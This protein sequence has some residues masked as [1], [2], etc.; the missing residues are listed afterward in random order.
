MSDSKAQPA[1]GTSVPLL[2][3]KLQ[4]QPLQ[5]EI[6]AAIEDLPIEAQHAIL[7]VHVNGGS[8]DALARSLGDEGL[9]LAQAQ[10]ESGYESL[11]VTLGVPFP[12]SFGLLK[13]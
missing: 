3:L 7:F 6:L 4:Y 11:S 9:V 5:K 13:K 8:I 2:D 1:L 10:L 12:D